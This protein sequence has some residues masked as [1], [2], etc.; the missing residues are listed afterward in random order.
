[1]NA[2]DNLME[3]RNNKEK[4][5]PLID[6]ETEFF[7]E[8][9]EYDDVNIGWDCGFIRNRPYFLEA[10]AT[11]GIT[12]ITIFLSTI[13]IEDYSVADLEKLLIEE[14]KIY[15]K[16]E[17]YESPDFVPKPVD[18]NGNEFFSINIVVGLE[19]E[20]ARIDGGGHLV[21]FNELNKLNGFSEE[22]EEAERQENFESVEDSEDED[23][24]GFF[25]DDDYFYRDDPSIGWKYYLKENNDG[26][27]VFLVQD[28]R[29]ID[30]FNSNYTIS[31]YRFDAENWKKFKDLL[32]AENIKDEI[33]QRFYTVSDID[34]WFDDEELFHFCQDNHIRKKFDRIETI[35][36]RPEEETFME[37]FERLCALEEH[38]DYV[39]P[40]EYPDHNYP[41]LED[42]YWPLIIDMK[43]KTIREVHDKT[44]YEEYCENNP[45]MNYS[46]F[47]GF[48]F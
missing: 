11:T 44:A 39:I 33:F 38:R 7:P 20:P 45:L 1:M 32:N 37:M 3:Y 28:A 10:W 35:W 2:I 29:D 27:A 42:G 47:K 34:N 6:H 31:E 23:E 43:E 18:D 15:T 48:Y 13:G 14:G 40:D 26:S 12:M 41:K 5:L 21:P 17:G 22:K 19:D 4:Y 16:R 46:E 25:I 8:R 9:T 24:E 36:F 30:P